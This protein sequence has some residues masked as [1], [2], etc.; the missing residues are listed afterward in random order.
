MASNSDPI[1]QHILNL[2]Y[3]HCKKHRQNNMKHLETQKQK[4]EAGSYVVWPYG[5]R[6]PTIL[7]GGEKPHRPHHH[8]ANIN[9]H[10]T[11]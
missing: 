9:C 2:T 4:S 11:Y 10:L 8:I 5:W 7:W 3:I 1:Y 6:S